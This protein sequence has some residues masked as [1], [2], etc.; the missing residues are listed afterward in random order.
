MP[1]QWFACRN[2]SECTLR[3]NQCCE[4]CGIADLSGAMAVN[5]QYLSA[6]GTELCRGASAICP[7]VDC[8]VPPT[9]YVAAQC[10]DSVCRAVDIRQDVLTACIRHADCYLRY[11]TGCCGPM[12]C[13]VDDTQLIS[14]AT[15]YDLGVCGTA[16]L[17]NWIC[18]VPSS[19][20]ALCS[21]G[22][23]VVGH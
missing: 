11:G 15:G 21:G 3:R 23:C 1:G 10:R 13:G 7:E 20:Q 19:Y 18:V 12:G 2:V 14:V 22:H 6:L 5:R 8:G 17:C 16:G 4:G 9:S